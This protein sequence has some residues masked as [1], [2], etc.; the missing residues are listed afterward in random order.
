M[1]NL[2]LVSWV[3]TAKS[4]V[5]RKKPMYGVSENSFEMERAEDAFCRV[6]ARI[7]PQYW[8]YPDNMDLEQKRYCDVVVDRMYRSRR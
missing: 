4:S 6:T 7:W 8:R 2:R 3:R 1:T 5:K